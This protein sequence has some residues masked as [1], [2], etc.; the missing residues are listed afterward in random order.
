VKER[1]KYDN[2]TPLLSELDW[3]PIEARIHHKIAD[4]TFKAVSTRKSSYLTEPVSIHIPEREFR[5]SSRRPNQLHVLT[6]ELH[7]AVERYV[8]LHQQC[9]AVCRRKLH[10]NTIILTCH[11]LQANQRHGMPINEKARH[12]VEKKSSVF[13]SCLWLLKTFK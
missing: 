13:K 4:V 11:I 7:S 5:S 10:Y 8:T 1:S 2:I 12:T 3:L 9:W 6:S